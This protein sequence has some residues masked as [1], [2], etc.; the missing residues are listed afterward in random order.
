MLGTRTKQVF[1]YGRRGQR[2]VNISDDH[3]NNIVNKNTDKAADPWRTPV[4]VKTK[5]R[6]HFPSESPSPQYVR[7]QNRGIKKK[8]RHSPSLSPVSLKKKLTRA[9]KLV[10]SDVASKSKT[11][12]TPT[13]QPLSLYHPNVPGSSIVGGKKKARVA[14]VKGTPLGGAKLSKPFSPFM[15]MDIIV[16]DHMGR[17]ISQERRISRTDVVVNPLVKDSASGS[18]KGILNK[19]KSRVIVLS[20]SEDEEAAPKP[21]KRPGGRAKAI[22]I[23]SDESEADEP[24]PDPPKAKTKA[25]KASIQPKPNVKPSRRLEV[26]VVMPMRLQATPPVMTMRASK[27]KLDSP[28][29]ELPATPPVRAAAKYLPVSISQPPRPR[30]LTPIRRGGSRSLFR[31]PSPPSPTTPTDLDISLDFDFSNLSLSPSQATQSI[32]P[33]EY[34]LP[35]L[36]EC[37][38]KT[39]HE[40]SAFIETFPFDPIVQPTDEDISSPN[41]VQFRKIGEASYSEVFGIGNVVLKVIPLRDDT[42]ASAPTPM[43]ELETPFPSEAKDVLKEMIVTRAMGEVCDGFIKLLRTY[44]V[45]GKYPELLLALWDEYDRSKGS[46]GVRPGMFNFS[47]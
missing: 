32:P 11:D 34:L 6:Q 9:R 19:Q 41:D 42:S 10:E 4:A 14:G 23:S 17:R 15:D 21:S 12:D 13:R 40:F 27:P 46:E 16:L 24:I 36:D 26:E 45:R 7:V 43:S 3:E 44:I 39:P 37:T 31:A 25:T 47:F 8:K 18:R 22:I 2:I 20:D 28:P 33:P 35:L 29:P 30:Q 1:S 5:M 38:Q